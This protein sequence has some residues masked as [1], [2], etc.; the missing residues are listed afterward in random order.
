MA[1]AGVG[2]PIHSYASPAIP[3]FQVVLEAGLVSAHGM[4][5]ATVPVGAPECWSKGDSLGEVD[6]GLIQLADLGVG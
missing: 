6:D 2:E 3:G 4:D 5:D 1:T